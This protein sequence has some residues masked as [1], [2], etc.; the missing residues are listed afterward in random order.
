MG[1][2]VCRVPWLRNTFGGLPSAFWTVWVGTLINR[3]GSF[4]MPLLAF[5]LTRE[6]GLSA[7]A[8]GVVVACY[9]AGSM[10]A[11]VIGGVL[12]DRIGRKKTMLLG[13]FGGAACMLGLGFAREPVE[14]AVAAFLVALVS[15]VYRPAVQACVAD[16]VPSEDR[17]RAYGA[18]YWA[19]NLGFAVAP[20]LAGMMAQVSYFALFIGDAISTFLYGCLLAFRLPETRPAETARAAAQPGLSVVFSDGVFMTFGVL[21]LALGLIYQQAHAAMPLDMAQKGLEPWETGWVLATNGILIVLI[22]PFLTRVVGKQRRSLILAAASLLTGFG[23]GLNALIGTMPLYMFAV[24]VWTL[25]EIIA[26]PAFSTIVADLAP[27]ALRG[28][29]QG[30]FSMSFGVASMLAPLAG[31]WTIEHYGASALWAACALTGILVALAHIVAAAPRRAR[32]EALRAAG[33]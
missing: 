33:Q 30:V 9:G 11:A 12:A 16:L 26:M 19:I 31:G 20:V 3:A 14:I 2:A 21:S 15:D 4:V 17:L 28:R 29:Y 8:A 10:L 7:P 13:L 27:V 24:A 23:F 18:L 32:I 1:H 22:Q 25:G 6:R 5:Y